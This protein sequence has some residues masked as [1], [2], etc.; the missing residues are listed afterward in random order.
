ME[1]VIEIPDRPLTKEEIMREALKNPYAITRE[2]NNRSLYHFIQYFWPTVSSNNF[3]PNWHIEYICKELEQV[4]EGVAGKQPKKHDL[5]I[6]ISPGTTKTIMMSIMFPAW[7]WT[8]WPWM[9]FITAS[10]S[11]DLSIESAD[12]CRDLIRSP[13]FYCV[14]PDIGIRE[15][16][17]T[18]TNFKIVRNSEGVGGKGRRSKQELVGGGRYSTSVGGTLMGFHGDILIVDD[19]LNPTEAASEIQLGIANHWMEQTLPTRKTN[20]DLSVIVLVMQRLHQDDPTGHWLSKNPA[21]LKHI[22]F[23]GEIRNYKNQ[24][25]PAEAS[26]YY[27]DD[28]FDPVRMP[29]MVLEELEK[30][31]GQYA[32]AGQIGQNPTPPGGGMFKVDHFQIMANPPNQANVVN[33]IRAWDK[34]GTT[35]KKSA[36]TAGVKIARL[37]DDKWIVLDVKRGKWATHEREK[38]IRETAESDGRHVEVWLEQE[39]GSSGKEA[40]ENTMRNLA[41]FVCKAETSTG[42]K[43]T[44]ADAFSVQVNIGCVQLLM[45]L[46]NKEYIEEFR[47]FP[48]GTYKDQVD[49]SSLAWNKLI[50]KK[51]ARRI[52]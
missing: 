39:P 18:R 44:R 31:M 52:T 7:C 45:G 27:I 11:K 6:N 43:I 28:L 21:K 51:I 29:W 1:E 48:F 20:K 8:K 47:F 25:C 49:A 12:Y 17:D 40:A 32:Y 42:D 9:R 26:R 24:V 15:D 23:P 33:T 37:A 34:A 14:Y 50:G 46:W 30:I 2:L 13:Q 35:T 3:Q 10:Y 16:K 4:A 41:G 36:Y 22:C 19:P 5:I 38:I